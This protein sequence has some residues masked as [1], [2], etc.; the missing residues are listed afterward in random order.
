[1]RKMK[2]VTINI[3]LVI[4]LILF[5]GCTGQDE[6]AMPEQV[7]QTNTHGS[8]PSRTLIQT[9]VP[10]SATTVQV[11][12]TNPPI[13]IFNG[14]Y[15][16]VEFLENDTVTMPP[17][18]RSSSF[19]TVKMER[20]ALS[21]NGSPAIRYKTTWVSD[22]AE[23]VDNKATKVKDGIVINDESFYDPAT[24]HLLSE[25]TTK[26]VKGT[27]PEQVDT[28]EYYSKHL[29]EDCPGGWI[30]ITPFEEMDIPLVDLGTDPV[31]VPLGHYEEARKLSGKFKDGTSISI[32]VVHGVPV[33]IKIEYPNKY[34][35][36]ED[37][38]QMFELKGWG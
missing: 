5:S 19:S 11:V 22:Y 17:N 9:S 21:L 13:R 34:M 36:G 31:D 6:T 26:S 7:Q 23:M 16:W 1:M 30:G 32:W 29:R 15:H 38:V 24:G 27:A 25:T 4:T 2:Q 18:P 3:L 35:D 33:P 10:Q 20:S 37:P 12:Q 28:S 14:E 8:T